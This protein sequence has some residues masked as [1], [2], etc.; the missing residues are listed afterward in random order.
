MIV[1]PQ[2]FGDKAPSQQ[3]LLREQ[4]EFFK[5]LLPSLD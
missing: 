2:A 4:D 3:E 5:K 1:Q